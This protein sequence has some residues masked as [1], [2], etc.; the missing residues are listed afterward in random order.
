MALN[1]L[2]ARLPELRL[3]YGELEGGEGK[4]VKYSPPEADVGITEL[5]VA[6]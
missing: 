5:L 4:S 1:T 3:A 2:F 6:W